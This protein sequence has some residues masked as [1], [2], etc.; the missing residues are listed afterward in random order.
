MG[1][2]SNPNFHAK[3]AKKMS[4]ERRIDIKTF[5]PVSVALV[6]S[7]SMPKGAFSYN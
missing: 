4:T 2:S 6:T 5:Y 3:K 7:F 1:S